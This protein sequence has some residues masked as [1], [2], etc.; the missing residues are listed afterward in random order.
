MKHVYL[1][2]FGCQMN[3]ADTDRMELLLFHSGYTRTQHAEDAD[4][5]LVNTCSIRDKA[6]QKVYSLFGSFRPLKQQNPD[7]L[8]G[9]A[10]CLAQQE[11]NQL[12]KRMPFLDFIIGPDAVEDVPLAVERVRREGKPVAWTEFDREKHYSIPV[13]A[14]VKPP[15]PSAF[16]NI[17]KGC[18]KFCSF[19]VVPFTRGREKSRE[20]SEIYEEARQLVDQGAREIILLGQNVNAYG[21]NG[22]QTPVAFH[23]LLYGIADIPGV[24]RL[25]FTTSHPRDFTAATIRAYRDLDKLVNHLHLPVQSGNDRVLDR[26]RRNHTV[27]AYMERIDALKEAVPGI[28]LST[29]IIVGF[30][31]ETEREFE[32][33]L[34]LMEQVEYSNSYMFAYSPRPNTPAALYEDSVPDEEKKRRLHATIELQSRLTEQ[35]GQRFVG[36]E[37]EVLIEGRTARKSLTFKGRNP[38]YWMVMFSGGEEDLKP[39]DTVRVKV[40]SAQNHVLKGVYCSRPV[41]TAATA[42]R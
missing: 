20:A 33:T 38:E 42:G 2:T 6:E 14:P 31:G 28:A 34:R 16:I 32:D 19:C 24:E 3:V 12:L 7:L 10:G 1:E 36:E 23:E 8:F 11:Q 5:I 15:G 17:I 37:V 29:D 22:L 27:D 26:M 39:G 21:K 13:V 41:G 35:L 40:E 9:L 18:D 4:L 25:R 30:P